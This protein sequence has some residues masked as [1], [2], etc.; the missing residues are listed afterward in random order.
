MKVVKFVMRV[1][2]V[3][4]V[5]EREPSPLQFSLLRALLAG[6]WP[7]QSSGSRSEISALYCAF[8]TYCVLAT[9][10]WQELY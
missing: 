5:S 2:P 1:M 10:W 7:G 4:S 8:L 9:D 3:S 6:E